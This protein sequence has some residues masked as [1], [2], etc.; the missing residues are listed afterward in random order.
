MSCIIKSEDTKIVFKKGA[1]G[2]PGYWLVDGKYKVADISECKIVGSQVD[3]A[4]V[5][6]T[7][8]VSPREAPT[9]PPAASDPVTTPHKGATVELTDVSEAQNIMTLAGDSVWG[10]IAIFALV[11]VFR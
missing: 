11:M 3:R 6:Q 5:V 9:P 8:D 7:A 10:G 2:A 4:L 1:N